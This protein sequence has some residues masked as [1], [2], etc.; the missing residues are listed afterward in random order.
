VLY[1]FGSSDGFHPFGPVVLGDGEVLHGTTGEGGPSGTGTVFSL[2]PPAYPGGSW[3]ETVLCDFADSTEGTFPVGGVVIGPGG[4]LYGTTQQGGSSN[5][6]TVFSLTPPASP[7][8]SWT[9][10]VLHSFTGGTDG[11]QPL[12][13]VVIDNSGALY[14]T[15]EYGGIKKRSCN[16]GC[17]T[18]FM[19][20]P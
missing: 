5:E 1:S 12:A 10:T 3:A 14:G 20:T 11:G 9:E 18:V 19:L 15:T 7:G 17:G 2:T 16:S 6:G 8:N 4:V 13:G